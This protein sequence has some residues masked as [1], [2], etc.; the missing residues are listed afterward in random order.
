M[1]PV[2]TLLVASTVPVNLDML[3]MVLTVWVSALCN[4][5]LSYRSEK[6]QKFIDHVPVI[7]T[8]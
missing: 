7:T 6:P 2:L 3:G 1:L 5:F 4:F 8:H